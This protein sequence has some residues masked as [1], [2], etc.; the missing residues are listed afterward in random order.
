MVDPLT[1]MAAPARSPTRPPIE[2][3]VWE[4]GWGSGPV[5]HRSGGAG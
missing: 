3:T 5:P 4:A 1:R 2:N